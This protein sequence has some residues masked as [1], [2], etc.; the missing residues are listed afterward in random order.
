MYGDADII[1]D[2]FMMGAFGIF[3]LEG[4]ALGKPV[5]TY[6]DEQ[7]LQRPV[8]D[9]PLVNTTPENLPRVLAALIASP[10]LRLRLGAAGRASV[11]RYQSFD[12]MAAVWTNIY[13][14][15]WWGTPLSL[16]STAPFD[17][18]RGTRST[19]EDPL[20]E[21]FWPVQVSDLMAVITGAIARV[22]QAKRSSP[23]TIGSES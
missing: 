9:H 22:D 12:A 1:A 10:E 18:A 11:V 13:R 2:Q 16:E 21:D 8:Y 17:A 15:L 4:M 23:G 6:L 14:H 5:L 3:A 20:R 7:H 19:T